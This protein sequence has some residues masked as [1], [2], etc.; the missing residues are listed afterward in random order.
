MNNIT[1]SLYAGLAKIVVEFNNKPSEGENGSVNIA[2]VERKTIVTQTYF[3][4]LV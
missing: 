1:N 3:E 2:R 4:T